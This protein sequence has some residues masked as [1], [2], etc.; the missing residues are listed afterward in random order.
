MINNT[1]DIQVILYW[2]SRKTHIKWFY[3]IKTYLRYTIRQA[4]VR[5]EVVFK[6]YKKKLKR[7][8]R[9]RG[10]PQRRKRRK[11]EKTFHGYGCMVSSVVTEYDIHD[12]R[13]RNN[14]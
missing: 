2:Y 5:Y 7:N 8:K 9:P 3:A 4:D 13:W 1:I 14:N 6:F 10:T 11:N 12:K